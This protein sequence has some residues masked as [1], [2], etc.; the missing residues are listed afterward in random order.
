MI[1]DENSLFERE[2]NEK[3]QLC[4]TWGKVTIYCAA[5]DAATSSNQLQ[6]IEI[7]IPN[8]DRIVK[9]VFF[10]KSAKNMGFWA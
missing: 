6:T 4:D 3:L 9:T 5:T 1:N 7:Q 10:S 8:E 2:S